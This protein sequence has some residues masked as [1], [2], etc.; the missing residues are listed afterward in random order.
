MFKYKF[1]LTVIILTISHTLLA[2]NPVRTQ[3]TDAIK[4]VPMQRSNAIKFPPSDDARP[5]AIC[6]NEDGK[7]TS[8]QETCAPCTH[9]CIR[10]VIRRNKVLMANARYQVKELQFPISPGIRAKRTTTKNNI[11]LEDRLVQQVVDMA[12]E[13]NGQDLIYICGNSGPI[14]VSNDPG[15]CLGHI[16]IDIVEIVVSPNRSSQ[17]KGN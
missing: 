12:E 13:P 8:T 16:L 15:D 5:I 3:P 6:V 4:L 14:I 7:W 11:I 9:S 17:A 10:A 1:F 2:Q